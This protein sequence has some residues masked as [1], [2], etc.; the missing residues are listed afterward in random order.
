MTAY[1]DSGVLIKLYVREANSATA[2]RSVSRYASVDINSFVELEIRNTFL[3]LEGR[4]I[5]SRG[6]RAASEHMLE[7]DIIAG[8]LRREAPNWQKVFSCALSL[9][10][11]FTV[12]TLARSMNI[13]HVAIAVVGSADLF[14][15]ADRRQESVAKR[16]GLQTEF[17][18]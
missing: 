2:V 11:D 9:S 7:R 5:I 16:A 18:A 6:Q 1:F 12:E 8:R 14:V 10:R 15:T 17:V 3:A 13:I 4:R